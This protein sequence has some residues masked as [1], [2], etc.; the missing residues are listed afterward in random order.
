VRNFYVNSELLYH[1]IFQILDTGEG[2]EWGHEE[3][4]CEITEYFQIPDAGAE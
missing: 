2:A 4:M 3:S 1:R